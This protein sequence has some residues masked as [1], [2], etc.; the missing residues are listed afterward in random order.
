MTRPL[1]LIAFAL[2]TLVGCNPIT[3]RLEAAKEDN[4]T[5]KA[6]YLLMCAKTRMVKYDEPLSSMDQLKEF[7]DGEKGAF[8]DPWGQPYQFKY[9]EDGNDSPPRLVI[10]TTHPKTGKVFAAPRELADK[11]QAGK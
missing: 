8:T 4:A 5:A 10:W 9:L 1:P 3:D 7:A 11:V 6:D 2:L